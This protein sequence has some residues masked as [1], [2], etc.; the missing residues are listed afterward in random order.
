MRAGETSWLDHCVSTEDGHG[1]ISDISIDYQS[2]ISDHIPLYIKLNINK[3]PIVMNENNNVTPKIK[4]ER[5]DSV[6]L[7]EYN[8]MTDINLH[9]ISLPVEVVN[10]RDN[11]CCDIEHIKQTKLVYDRICKSL[12]NAS[13]S[14]LGTSNKGK[15]N[16]KPG[17]NEHVRE[18]HDIA[19]KRFVAWINTN[20]HEN[21]IILFSGR[22]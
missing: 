1:L 11:L 16:C 18:K 22:W 12:V 20:R 6:K 7:R 4:W 5:Y 21:L 14:V 9:S 10:C 13:C 8:L 3:L 2:A 17:F 15:F 19:R